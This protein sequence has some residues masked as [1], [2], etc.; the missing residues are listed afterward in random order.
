MTGPGND[1]RVGAGAAVD[2]VVQVGRMVVHLDEPPAP[3]PPPSRPLVGRVA[4]LAAIDEAFGAGRAGVVLVGPGGIGTTSIARAWA[5]RRPG[6]T[7]WIEPRRAPGPAIGGPDAVLA[8]YG[9]AAFSAVVVDGASAEDQVRPV[10]LTASPVLVTTRRVMPGLAVDGWAHLH[11]APLGPAEG[12]AVLC[13]GSPDG[14]AWRSGDGVARL[15]AHCDGHVAT[16]R[17]LAALAGRFGGPADLIAALGADAPLDAAIALARRAMSALDLRVLDSV[18]DAG[19]LD[20][21]AA[22]AAALSGAGIPE[23][24]AALD[25]LAACGLLDDDGPGAHRV[26]AWLRER[27]T[28][29]IGLPAG[30][31]SRQEERDAAVSAP[32]P[33]VDLDTVGDAE[34]VCAIAAGALR[35]IGDDAG[36]ALLLVRLARAAHHA[37]R[38]AAALDHA[39]RALMLFE[40]FGDGPGTARAMNRIAAV[41][42]DAGRLTDALDVIDGAIAR[43]GNGIGTAWLSCTR[44]DVLTRLGRPAESTTILTGAINAFDRAGER[45]GAARAWTLLAE[46]RQQDADA[47]GAAAAYRAAIVALGPSATPALTECLDILDG[48]TVVHLDEARIVSGVAALVGP[49]TGLILRAVNT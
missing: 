30:G 36:E 17:L 12:A 14:A 47:A 18:L 40:K 48:R 15:V 19:M 27:A 4:E 38:H 31:G 49:E 44:A 24:T 7:A 45:Y 21:D 32:E 35:K 46:A 39:T 26:P 41:L 34:R 25:R 23:A 1:L 9:P 20:T 3:R 5:A 8:R 42:R 37:G 33:A 29:R 16:L 28:S 13:S 11:V 2:L 22:T 43:A 6:R 10:A